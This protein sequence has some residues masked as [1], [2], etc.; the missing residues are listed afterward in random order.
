MRRRKIAPARQWHICNSETA[1]RLSSERR[2]CRL[3]WEL[4]A[5]CSS[6]WHCAQNTNNLGCPKHIIKIAQLLCTHP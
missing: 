3:S 6:V 2:S 1:R 4:D 5:G